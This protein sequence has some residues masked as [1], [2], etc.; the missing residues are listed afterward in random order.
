MSQCILKRVAQLVKLFL[1]T[2]TNCFCYL[3]QFNVGIE[4][5]LERKED[6]GVSELQEMRTR[7]KKV[8]STL[9][10]QRILM[11]MM[12]EVRVSTDSRP[13]AFNYTYVA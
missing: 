9:E 11:R 12:T 3:N 2:S 8:Y 1:L 7:L 4:H 5:V 13:V 10:K 6:T